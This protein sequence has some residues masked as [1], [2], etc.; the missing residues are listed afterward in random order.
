MTLTFIVF[1][2]PT[3]RITMVAAPIFLSTRILRE[4]ERRNQQKRGRSELFQWSVGFITVT[5]GK[6]H[7]GLMLMGDPKDE[8]SEG[9]ETYSYGGT[10]ST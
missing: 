7:N 6:Q 4:D 2:E 8:F 1:E 3:W 9:T 10:L 5:P